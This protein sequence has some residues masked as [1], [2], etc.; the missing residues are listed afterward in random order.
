[1]ENEMQS[2]ANYICEPC[3]QRGHQDFFENPRQLT[4]HIDSVSEI[5]LYF[6][7]LNTRDKSTEGREDCFIHFHP[8]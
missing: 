6:L 5:G 7:S 2:E 8:S 4:Y 1:M 3:R